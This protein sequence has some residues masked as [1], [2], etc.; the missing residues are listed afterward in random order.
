[1]AEPIARAVSKPKVGAFSGSGRSLSIVLGTVA[2]P[3]R[4]F[5]SAAM[6]VA[7]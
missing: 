1:M 4:P 2:T 5:V 7:P 6:R 3:I